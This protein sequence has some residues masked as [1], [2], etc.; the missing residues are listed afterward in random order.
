MDSIETTTNTQVGFH[1]SIDGP[2][3]QAIHTLDQGHAL[4][5]TKDDED[6]QVQSG[7]SSTLLVVDTTLL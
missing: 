2:L 7:T 6:D 5:S 3:G 1:L 4:Q